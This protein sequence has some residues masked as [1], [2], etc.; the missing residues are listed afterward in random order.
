MTTQKDTN[1]SEQPDSRPTVVLDEHITYLNEWRE[2]GEMNLHH[3]SGYLQD[4]FGLSPSDAEE[5]L[6][7]W[8]H[9]TGTVV[10]TAEDLDYVTVW[11]EAKELLTALQ[12]RLKTM[13]SLTVEEQE[14]LKVA[15]VK[16]EDEA[17]EGLVQR[18]QR[19]DAF[20][21]WQKQLEMLHA[22]LTEGALTPS[23]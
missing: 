10:A 20:D 12:T 2:A 23:K 21:T 8:L 18:S 9:A 13:R 6:R 11:E 19:M 4:G 15:L 7:Y 1:M 22:L 17:Y 5:V 14:A 16:G 3:A